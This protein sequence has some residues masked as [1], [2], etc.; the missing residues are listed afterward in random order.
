MAADGKPAPAGRPA[1]A[2]RYGDPLPE[3]ALARL[4]TVRLRL[5]HNLAC[6]SAAFAPKGRLLATGGLGRIR[7]WDA[8]D[9]RL[10][11]QAI[12]E[13]Y[14]SGPLVFA[15]DG[16]WLAACGRRTALLDPRT[17]RCLRVLGTSASVLAVS[18][19]GKLLAADDGKGVSLWDARAGKEVVRL[20]GAGPSLVFFRF[21]PDG[22]TLAVVERDRQG[23]AGGLKVRRWDVA[24]RGLV[25]EV[26]IPLPFCRT[27]ELAPDGRTLAAV[28]YDTTPVRLYDTATGKQRVRLRG[29]LAQSSYG[30]AFS[31]DGRT[32]AT[33]W[34][35]PGPDEGT[36]SLWDAA[37]GKLRRRF[38]AP[39]HVLGNHFVFAPDGRTLLTTGSDPLVR[40]WDTATGRRVLE[41]PA[42]EGAVGSLAFTADGRVLVSGSHD[43]TVR[44]WDA[45]TGRP[46]RAIRAHRWGVNRVALLPGG[47]E[48]LSCGPDG[49]LRLWDLGTGK[50]LRRLVVDPGAEK[51]DD[52]T[53]AQ[54]VLSLA[55][56]ADG[57]T[58]VSCSTGGK[59]RGH[60][61][62]VWEL[63][64]GKVLRR[65]RVPA[66]LYV[67][68]FSPDGRLYLCWRLQAGPRLKGE[69]P[70]PSLPPPVE[71]RDIATD[72]P[73]AAL[74]HRDQDGAVRA[75]SPDGR[76]L[77]TAT[78]RLV[79]REKGQDDGRHALHFWELAS[80]KE[81]LTITTRETGPLAPLTRFVRAAFAPDGRALA[82]A[83]ADGLIQVW[84]VATGKELLR[85]NGPGPG[86]PYRFW[87]VR[88][89]DFS[90]D[91]K[92]LATGHADST[93]LVWDVAAA[94]RR[95]AAARSAAVAPP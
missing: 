66:G 13:G 44:L 93:I 63:H 47:R 39:R 54:Q 36:I 76:V 57:R 25:G 33:S 45:A 31:P 70:L 95:G 34:P 6:L 16:S 9:G 37:G 71:V 87:P 59:R 22:R 52:L 43:G 15:P 3:G 17:G 19:D 4:G 29:E 28:P 82:T 67:D 80:G 72:R 92:R 60:Q 69:E 10:L 1:G 86:R 68:G 61:L 42:H 38:R 81:R 41:A 27:L 11:W 73:V 21:T 78:S 94:A 79:R 58:A 24:T 55:V 77:V 14:H 90:P 84:D 20:P 91:G 64:S 74:A 30:V 23:G 88:C 51:R 50:E 8:A 12:E 83:R 65:R 49:C 2:D 7:L 48:A 40:L 53:F 35:G 46:A 85:R 75:F 18:P 62:D 89:L 5:D 26:L 32:L 56:A